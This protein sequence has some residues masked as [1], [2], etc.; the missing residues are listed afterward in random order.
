MDRGPDCLGW[1]LK[2]LPV[3]L[4]EVVFP[5]VILEASPYNFHYKLLNGNCYVI[6]KMRLID[7]L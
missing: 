2:L 6:G 7:Y 1:S 4:Q 5:G 3:S